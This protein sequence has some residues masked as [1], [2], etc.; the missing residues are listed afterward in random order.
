[1]TSLWYQ[2][3]GGSWAK[4]AG[5]CLERPLWLSH[6]PGGAQCGDDSIKAG[7]MALSSSVSLES[8]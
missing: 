1:M 8:V 5:P 4:T 2:G 6:Y 3:Q 7:A